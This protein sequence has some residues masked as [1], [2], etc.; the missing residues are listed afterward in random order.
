ME[1]EI[2]NSLYNY[3]KDFLFRRSQKIVFNEEY[4]SMFSG[5]PHGGNNGKLLFL[6]YIDNRK[7]HV[8][9]IVRGD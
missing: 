6:E 1:L 8:D 4:L 3:F 7:L 5:A 9:K 2:L